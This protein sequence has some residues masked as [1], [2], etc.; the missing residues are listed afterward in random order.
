MVGHD[1]SLTYNNVYKRFWFR[2]LAMK[3]EEMRRVS[4][5]YMLAVFVVA[6]MMAV[7]PT[8]VEAQS[9]RPDVRQMTCEQVRALVE[10]S[11]GIVLTTG[12]YTY[13]R[14]VSDRL[15]CPMGLDTKDAWVATQDNR[16]CRIGYTCVVE[17]RFPRLDF[18]N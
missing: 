11:G 1:V 17:P 2:C 15:Y 3:V 12:Q 18:R 9:R 10:Q 5:F 16:S 6:S 7:H 4:G 8:A 13:D 14:Y